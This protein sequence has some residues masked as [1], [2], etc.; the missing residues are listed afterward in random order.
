VFQTASTKCEAGPGQGGEAAGDQVPDRRRIARHRQGQD[1]G[2]GRVGARRP[3]CAERGAAH[4]QVIGAAAGGHDIGD[5]VAGPAA[6]TAVAGR[7]QDRD[8]A[9]RCIDEQLIDR[10][11]E[12]RARCRHRRVE[13]VGRGDDVGV[14][15]RIPDRRLVGGIGIRVGVGAE[16][17]AGIEDERA[18]R[19]DRR[20]HAD[21]ERAFAGVGGHLLAAQGDRRHLA[22]RA[23]AHGLAIGIQQRLEF[24]RRRI[25]PE[26]VADPGFEQADRAGADSVAG[27]RIPRRPRQRKI[28]EVLGDV[29]RVEDDAA[30]G[31]AVA[32][33]LC[34][35]RQCRRRAAARG[36]QHRA[37]H[38]GVEPQALDAQGRQR[39]RQRQVALPVGHRIARL[40]VARQQRRAEQRGEIALV[41]LHPD[42]ARLGRRHI[43]VH[44]IDLVDGVDAEPG[45]LGE[46]LVVGRRIG[47]VGRPQRAVVG[48]ALELLLARAPIGIEQCRRIVRPIE[49][50]RHVEGEI[51]E[52][53]GAGRRGRVAAVAVVVEVGR[54]RKRCVLGRHWTDPRCAMLGPA[55]G[56]LPARQ[57]HMTVSFV[58]QPG[59]QGRTNI[60]QWDTK[61][62]LPLAVAMR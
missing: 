4:H 53:S 11:Q 26:R 61:M 25:R 16:T 40:V 15:Q 10:E 47:A 28:V 49:H 41:D 13:A 51:A 37:E 32:D 62:T 14:V 12:R 38:V 59:L 7:G 30:A 54:V 35:L 46:D 23:D 27:R 60:R 22:G 20:H 45:Q 3:Q 31:R 50:Q 52:R 39:L 19:V 57:M 1:V 33:A 44:G 9:Q 43:A 29:L 42:R 58:A 18:L 21:I 24:A 2:Q 17:G 36:R 5:A 6:G 34:A 48:Q 8:A 56:R 55:A